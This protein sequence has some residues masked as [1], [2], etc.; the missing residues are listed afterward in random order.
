MLF[1]NSNNGKLIG[2]SCLTRNKIQDTGKTLL[3]T[4]CLMICLKFQV[5]Y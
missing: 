2:I 4:K 3:F 5:D 1:F